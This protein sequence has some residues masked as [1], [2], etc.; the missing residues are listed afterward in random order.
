MLLNCAWVWIYPW[1]MEKYLPVAT[2]S[3]KNDHLFPSSFQLPM[4]RCKFNKKCHSKEWTMENISP[5]MVEVCK[6]EWLGLMQVRRGTVSLC[7]MSHKVF[8]KKNSFYRQ[9]VSPSSQFYIMSLIFSHNGPWALVGWVSNKNVAF[10]DKCSQTL[11][12]ST[13]ICLLCAST[14]TVDQWKKK[15]RWKSLRAPQVYGYKDVYLKNSL[16]VWPFNLTLI[17]GFTLKPKEM[18]CWQELDD[19]A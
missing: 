1:S 17:I 15:L 14:L 19:Q 11:I 3:N 12:L 5:S 6:L 9:H 10:M 4:A 7:V 13:W 8:K 16:T 2:A 18:D